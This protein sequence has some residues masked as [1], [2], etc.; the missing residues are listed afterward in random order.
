[1]TTGGYQQDHGIREQSVKKET[2]MNHSLFAKR[3]TAIIIAVFLGAHAGAF[4]GTVD[5][6]RAATSIHVV[7]SDLNLSSDA[8]ISTLY[9]RLHGAARTVCGEQHSLRLAGSLEQLL[10]N[11]QCY[12]SVLT[13]AVSS[14]D[15]TRLQSIHRS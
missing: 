12:D 8:G 2:I 1:M 15:N 13:R 3:L 14:F 6:Y 10:K 5:E 9:R 7:Y 4:A 11:K